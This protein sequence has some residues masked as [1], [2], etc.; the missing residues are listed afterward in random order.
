VPEGVD[1]PG[2]GWMGDAKGLLDEAVASFDLAYDGLE[3][4]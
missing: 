1:L 4:A 2:Y 3:V